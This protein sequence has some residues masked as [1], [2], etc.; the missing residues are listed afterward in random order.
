MKINEGGD[1]HEHLKASPKGTLV[2]IPFTLINLRYEGRFFKEVDE[3]LSSQ[4]KLLTEVFFQ[5]ENYFL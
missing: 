3:V 1:N 5:R 4:I 2:L